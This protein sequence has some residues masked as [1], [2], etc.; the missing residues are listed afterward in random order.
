MTEQQ[1]LFGT[2]QE[3]EKMPRAARTRDP[4]TSKLGEQYLRISGKRLTLCEIVTNLVRS[5]PN[6]TYTELWEQHRTDCGRLG[7]V[8]PFK[9]PE[10]VMKRLNDCKGK[11]IE[12]GAARVCKWTGSPAATWHALKCEAKT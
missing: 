10:A 4:S 1:G 2:F 9:S 12:K 11:T 5:N 6:S 8:P 3:G 7:M